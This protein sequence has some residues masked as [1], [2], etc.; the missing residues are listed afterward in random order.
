[1]VD[2]KKLIERQIVEYVTTL[3]MSYIE[4]IVH[5]SEQKDVDPESL[6]NLLTNNIIKN[7]KKEAKELN[8]IASEKALKEID[9]YF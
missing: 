9:K 5:Y 3:N 8:L 4:A 7:V 1:M 2:K 6:G